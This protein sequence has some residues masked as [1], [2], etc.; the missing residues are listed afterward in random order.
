MRERVG[1]VDREEHAL[2]V[3]GTAE[4]A[5]SIEQMRSETLPA[6]PHVDLQFE[7]VGHLECLLRDKSVGGNACNGPIGWTGAYCAVRAVVR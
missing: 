1:Q 4:I 6:P 7:Q 2:A 3:T 5:H